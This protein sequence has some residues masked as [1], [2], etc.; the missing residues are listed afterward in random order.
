MKCIKTGLDVILPNGNKY[1]GDLYRLGDPDSLVFRVRLNQ[2]PQELPVDRYNLY[3]STYITSINV[4]GDIREVDFHVH[5][6]K[7]CSPDLLIHLETWERDSS[8]V[9]AFQ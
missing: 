5:N 7:Y 4:R 8:I 6:I 3:L 1:R 2:Q 9:Q